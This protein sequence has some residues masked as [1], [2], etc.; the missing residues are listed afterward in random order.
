[1]FG[2]RPVSVRMPTVG[3]LSESLRSDAHGELEVGEGQHQNL[4]DSRARTLRS[5]HLDRFAKFDG[6]GASRLVVSEAEKDLWILAARPDPTIGGTVTWWRVCSAEELSAD[7]SNFRAGVPAPIRR[8]R[9]DV[10]GAIRLFWAH[11]SAKAVTDARIANGPFNRIH[12]R[13]GRRGV[14]CC[15]R[16]AQSS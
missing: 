16:F 12:R 3:M 9:E 15:R 4:L 1:M 10:S 5:G 11:R 7:H 13:S 14:G 6:G 8:Q 2:N